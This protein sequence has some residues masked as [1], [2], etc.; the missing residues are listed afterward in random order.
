MEGAKNLI[1]PVLFLGA[2]SEKK[3][4]KGERVNCASGVKR[5]RGKGGRNL[6]LGLQKEE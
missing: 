3:R 4:E 6:A 2:E 5:T 1:L